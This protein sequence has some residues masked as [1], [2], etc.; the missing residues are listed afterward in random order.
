[1]KKSSGNYLNR[2]AK[3]R[4][5]LTQAKILEAARALVDAGG[6]AA[7]TMRA[8]AQRLGVAAM[9]VYNHFRDRDAILDTIADDVFEQL[10]QKVVLSGQVGQDLSLWRTAVKSVLMSAQELAAQHPD[11][12]RLSMTRPSKPA[13]AFALMTEV[14]TILEGIGLTKGQALTAYHTFAILLQGYPFWQEGF[15]RYGICLAGIV[16][17]PANSCDPDASLPLQWS[18][19]RQF[20]AVVDWLLDCVETMS[21]HQHGDSLKAP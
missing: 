18:A 7:L 10:R 2:S 1:M 19:Q 17:T 15:E 4:K 21:R 9:A 14:L 5:G 20:E 12:F 16:G 8:L 13:S 6:P 11:V 3:V